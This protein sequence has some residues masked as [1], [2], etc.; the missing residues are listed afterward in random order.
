MARFVLVARNASYVS[1]RAATIDRRARQPIRFNG[2][3]SSDLSGI[4]SGLLASNAEFAP[5]TDDVANQ[6]GR[7]A[8]RQIAAASPD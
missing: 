2:V 1:L 8:N 5:V 7:L 3:E 6:L 4:P